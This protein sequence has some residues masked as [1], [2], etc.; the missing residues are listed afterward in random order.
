M[1][2]REPRLL[3]HLRARLRARGYTRVVATVARDLDE[4][5]WVCTVR[6]GVMQSLHGWARSPWRHRAI[7]RA[8]RGDYGE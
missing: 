4:G 3:R 1:S 5:G 8:F 6:R 2:R 7:Q